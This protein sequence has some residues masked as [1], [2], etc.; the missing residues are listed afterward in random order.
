MFVIQKLVAT[1]VPGEPAWITCK[2]GGLLPEFFTDPFTPWLV[3]ALCYPN[4]A[5]SQI[6]IIDPDEVDNASC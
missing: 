3:A 6:R 1:D 5:R 2:P 4:V